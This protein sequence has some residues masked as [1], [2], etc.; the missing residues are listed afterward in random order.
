MPNFVSIEYWGDW[1]AANA[2][3]RKWKD[4]NPGENY[5]TRIIPGK[6]DEI[7]IHTVNLTTVKKKNPTKTSDLKLEGQTDPTKL[8]DSDVGYVLL[9][10]REGD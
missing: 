2:R 10:W 9:M 6:K 8:E 4:E 3:R 1:E 5:K 7:G